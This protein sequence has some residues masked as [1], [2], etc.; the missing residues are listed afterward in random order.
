[1]AKSFFQGFFPS[2]GHWLSLSL[3][4]FSYLD[5]SSVSHV[6]KPRG[7]KD[8]CSWSQWLDGGLADWTWKSHCSSVRMKPACWSVQ[9]CTQLIPP[10]PHTFGKVVGDRCSFLTLEMK[11]QPCLAVDTSAKAAA[12][13]TQSWLSPTSS[14]LTVGRG[15]QPFS[16]SKIELQ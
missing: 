4:I 12:R 1:M 7:S 2:Q 15:H 16:C 9:S 13:V 14:G 3:M 11:L 8:S 5:D 10:P 6:H